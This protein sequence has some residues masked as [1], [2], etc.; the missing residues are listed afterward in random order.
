MELVRDGGPTWSNVV[1]R[2]LRVRRKLGELLVGKRGLPARRQELY[3]WELGRVPMMKGLQGRNWGDERLR[4]LSEL[5]PRWLSHRAPNL[6]R[7]QVLRLGTTSG[8]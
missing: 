2:D 4:A 5:I 7:R 1:R 3:L 6:S 8:D